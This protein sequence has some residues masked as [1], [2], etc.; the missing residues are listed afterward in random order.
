MVETVCG[1]D[2]VVLDVQI[3]GSATDLLLTE[4][5]GKDFVVREGHLLQDDDVP[6]PVLEASGRFKNELWSEFNG[7]NDGCLAGFLIA[8][9]D[10]ELV[11]VKLY[12]GLVLY[13]EIEEEVLANSIDIVQTHIH[14]VHL[15]ADVPELGRT[16]PNLT[17]I[18]CHILGAHGNGRIGVGNPFVQLDVLICHSLCES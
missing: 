1:K 14:S 17:C 2:I 13:A 7:L 18:S 11:N 8:E 9:L 5:D 6:V 12:V 4:F 15:G 16:V 3:D 10:S